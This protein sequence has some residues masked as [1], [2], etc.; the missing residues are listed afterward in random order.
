V[1][2]WG[3][4]CVSLHTFLLGGGDIGSKVCIS[5]YFSVSMAM[6]Y[7]LKAYNSMYVSITMVRIGGLKH[8]PL[9][10]FRL[11]W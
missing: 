5:T 1:V 3:L 4:R 7:V 10:A 8:I 6:I 2:I 9:H 11:L